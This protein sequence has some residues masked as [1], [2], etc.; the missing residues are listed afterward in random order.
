MLAVNGALGF[1]SILAEAAF[2]RQ[3]IRPQS[4]SEGASTPSRRVASLTGHGLTA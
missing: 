4:L 2:E 1:Y 3:G